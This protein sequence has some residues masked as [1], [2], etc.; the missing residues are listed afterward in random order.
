MEKTFQ[1]CPAIYRT[2][3]GTA[4]RRFADRTSLMRYLALPLMALAV[5]ALFIALFLGPLQDFAYQPGYAADF[6]LD[7]ALLFG[8]LVYASA[9]FLPSVDSAAPTIFLWLIYLLFLLPRAAICSVRN[10]E[11]GYFFL[12]FFVF[13]IAVF[14]NYFLK[15]KK[16]A[17]R[18]IDFKFFNKVMGIANIGLGIALVALL[19]Y[20]FLTKGIPTLAAFNFDIT[21]EIRENNSAS[22]VVMALGFFFGV[23][24]IPLLLSS[25]LVQ[26]KYKSAIALTV[27]ELFLFLW[28]ANKTWLFN[29]VLIWGLFCISRRRNLKPT[30]IAT[31]LLALLLLLIILMVGIDVESS[32]LDTLFS[33]F[34]RRLIVVPAILGYSYYQFFLTHPVVFLQNTFLSFLTPMP[35]YYATA[36]YQNM[37]GEAVFGSSTSWA[38]TGLFGAEYAQFGFVSFILIVINLIIFLVLLHLS[39]GKRVVSFQAYASV[40]FAMLLLNQSSVRILYSYTG[41]VFMLCYCLLLMNLAKLDLCD[42]NISV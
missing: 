30:Y 36:S 21:Y 18:V 13:Y 15:K 4:Q 2:E 29:I 37:A 8:C 10:L 11:P 5:Y 32:V 40:L 20:Y 3:D 25:C 24:M 22:S 7:K 31:I 14:V 1:Q 9:M 19:A 27:A 38:N 42:S 33:L 16:I 39:G 28:T 23:Q 26:S 35:D 17:F 12:T 6:N 34:I 41:V